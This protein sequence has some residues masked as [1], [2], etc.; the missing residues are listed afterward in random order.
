MADSPLPELPGRRS[1]RIPAALFLGLLLL[2]E[3]NGAFL[4]V[5]DATTNLYLPVQILTRGTLTFS[6]EEMPFMFLWKDLVLS[7]Q[8]PI[9]V[10][11]WDDKIFGHVAR[12]LYRG[13]TLTPAQPRYYLVPA[14]Q[15]G[16]YV[17]IYGPGAGL[18]ALPYF[19]LLSLLRP[20]WRDSTEILG[21]EGKFF[22]SLAIAGSAVFVYLA[23]LRFLSRRRALLLALLY[24][25]GTCVWTEPSQTLWQ[26]T[27]A[28]FFVALGSYL[29]L[30][31]TEGARFAA[32]CGAALGAATACRPGLALLLGCVGAYALLKERK[33]LP[34]LVLGGAPPVLLLLCFNARY[35]GSPFL[36]GQ[37]AAARVL[38]EHSTASGAWEGSWGAGLAGILLSPSR[39]LFV[40]SPFLLFALW[41]AVRS[42]KT[43]EHAALRPLGI[44]VLLGFGLASRWFEWW[45][46]W[47]FGYRMIV[48]LTPLCVL[49]LMPLGDRLF[50]RRAPA[51]VFGLLAFL[52]VTIQAL[53]AFGYET[54]TWNNRSGYRIQTERGEEITTME[55]S[56]RRAAEGTAKPL[57]TTEMD[58]SKP[59]FRH[60][61]WSFRDGQIA[62]LLRPHA[63]REGHEHRQTVARDAASER[64]RRPDEP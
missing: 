48:E 43:P 63:V 33:A 25:A 32:G 55:E 37:V 50:D 23:L 64:A 7:P 9:R 16:R 53:G 30:R 8:K 12:D 18:S 42:W 49:L 14:V 10:N 17:G 21:A 6:P 56:V 45:G 27:P 28:I 2:Y 51:R 31:I 47:S 35:L 34:A 3:I 19:A 62:W 60:R 36:F 26:Q 46:G 58:V 24:G 22:A 29:L 57:G 11:S 61:L 1:W 5:G 40:F 52:S 44:A 59:E 4:R 54:S 41:G 13:G 15:P 39:G 20:D 38:T